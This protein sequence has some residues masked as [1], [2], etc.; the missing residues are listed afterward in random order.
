MNLLRSTYYHNS[1]SCSG[2]N[3]QELIDPE[4]QIQLPFFIWEVYKC[5]RLH[6]SFGYRPPVEFEELFLENKNLYQTILIGSV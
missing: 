4:V 1:K 5:K 3:D 2:E 6:S